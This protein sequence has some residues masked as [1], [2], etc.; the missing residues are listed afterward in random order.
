MWLDAAKNGDELLKNSF[1]N[2]LSILEHLRPRFEND[3]GRLDR[4]LQEILE[5][6]CGSSVRL[7]HDTWIVDRSKVFAGDPEEFVSLY[8]KNG[9]EAPLRI[10]DVGAGTGMVAIK[11]AQAFPGSTVSI[12]EPSP[13]MRDAAEEN[14]R[15]AGVKNVIFINDSIANLAP[16]YENHFDLVLSLRVAHFNTNILK[17]WHQL[18]RF[19]TRRG[20]VLASEFTLPNVLN[21]EELMFCKEYSCRCT[22]LLIP[23]LTKNEYED[24]LRQAGLQMTAFGVLMCPPPTSVIPCKEDF[25]RL[26]RTLRKK[27]SVYGLPPYTTEWFMLARS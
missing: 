11:F 16:K 24:L 1:R 26:E 19:L 2:E 14:I 13:S 20:T 22:P 12:I 15:E 21:P 7:Q 18:A 4:W 10:L 25:V 23:P 17:Y 9:A 8:K 5:R 6:D 3:S 27:Y